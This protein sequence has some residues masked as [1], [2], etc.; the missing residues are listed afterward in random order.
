MKMKKIGILTYHR[1]TNYGAF[2]QAWSLMQF[3]GNELNQEV[4]VIDYQSSAAFEAERKVFL[5]RWKRDWI[6]PVK[7]NRLV[8]YFKFR[9]WQWLYFNSSIFR[10]PNTN[11]RHLNCKIV[12]FG[13]DEIWNIT[14]WYKTIDLCFFGFGLKHEIVKIAYAPSIGSSEI[15][16]FRNNRQIENLL[17]SFKDLSVRDSH[18]QK[19][20]HQ[21]GFDAKIVLDPTFLIDW[22][23]MNLVDSNF[24]NGRGYILLNISQT[25]KY[26]KLINRLQEIA[27]SNDWDLLNLIYT[28]EIEDV[29]N[30]SSPNPFQWVKYYANA[31]HVVTDTFHGTVFAINTRRQFTILDP[32]EKSNKIKGV[33]EACNITRAFKNNDDFILDQAIH[34]EV[35]EPIIQNKIIVS[36]EYLS[37]SLE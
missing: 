37:Q 34:Y 14:N 25:V 26:G 20:L 30:V 12:I 19:I 24:R 8:K 4:E 32:G 2:L 3:L 27:K 33:L 1:G 17:M 18:S 23:L 35:I 9:Y 28:N 13:S 21:Y 16:S 10:K 31:K 11:L 22:K 7:L 29:D 5:P 6:K 15:D 36:K